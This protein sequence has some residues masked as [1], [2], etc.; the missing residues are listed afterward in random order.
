MRI[1]TFTSLFPNA[2]D[3]TFGVFIYQRMAHVNKRPGNQVVVVAPVP[4]LPSW[5]KSSRWGAMARIPRVE[6]IGELTVHHPRYLL[7]PKVSMAVHGLLMFLG[8]FRL[9]LKL[10]RELKFDCIDAHYVYPDCFAAVMIGRRLHLPVIASARGTDI[11]LFPSFR[12]VR[13]MIRRTLQ[14]TAGNIGVC[15][16]LADEM[17]ALGAQP[18]R[19]TVIG[20]GVDL[21]RFQPVEQAEA[22]RKL[23]I[24]ADAQVIVAVGALIPR[25]GYQFLIPAI[26]AIASQYPRLKAYIV[27]KGDRTELQELCRKHKVEDRV[28]LVGSRPNEELSVWYS[29][30]DLSCL[31]SSREG[32]PNVVLESLA[33][34]T[35][36]VATGL[37][38]VP[39]ILVSP[40]LGIMVAQEPQAIADGLSR[41]LDRSWDRTAILKYARTRTWD[42][43]AQE[44]EQYLEQTCNA[45]HRPAD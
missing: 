6:Q 15:R 43:V 18:E 38:G 35:P 33:C 39:E 4:Y 27:G 19:V 13:P 37:W 24:P 40:E 5:L 41:A 31:V 44:V 23:E 2:A 45:Q 21:E 20:N 26:A 16:A 14:R 3:K 36:V 32:W 8:S 17:I 12:L 7:L 30:A 11:N 9:V 1:L 28:F 29:A 22:R 25:K 10:H 34:G 42:V